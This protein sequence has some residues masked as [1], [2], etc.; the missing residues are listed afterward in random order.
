MTPEL[1]QNHTSAGCCTTTRGARWC[2]FGR[3][4]HR[5]ATSPLLQ[6]PP[7]VAL[8]LAAGTGILSHQTLGPG[9]RVCP[10]R[11]RF[12][13]APGNILRTHRPRACRRNSVRYRNFRGSRTGFRGPV[14]RHVNTLVTTTRNGAILQSCGLRAADNTGAAEDHPGA[15]AARNSVHCKKKRTRD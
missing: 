10:A 5:G 13:I 11:N 7:P 1:S 9:F 14:R 12:S 3:A 4:P 8:K 6:Q 2:L 15:A